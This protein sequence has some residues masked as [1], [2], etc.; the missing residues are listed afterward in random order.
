MTTA[1]ATAKPTP[2]AEG[3]VERIF[4]ASLAALDIFTIYLGDR[5]GLYRVLNE[6]G[7]LD[8]TGLAAAAGIDERYALEWLEQQATT[9]ILEYRGDGLFELPQPYAK[10]L[11]ERDDA[12][13]FAPLARM[14]VSVGGTMPR[15]VEAYKTGAGIDWGDYSPDLVEGQSE[16]NR[17]FFLGSF[18]KDVLPGIPEVDGALRQRGARAAE[19]GFG[20]GWAA[21]AIAGEYADVTVAGF[22]IDG[23]S[24]EMA[25]ANALESGVADRVTFHHVDA[26]KVSGDGTFDVVYAVECIHDMANPVAALKA[27]RDLVKPGGHVLVLDEAVGEE[28]TGAVDDTERFFYGWSATA[29]LLNGRVEQ[30]SNA[31]GT[32]IRP[33]TLERL[34]REAGFSGIEVADVD[35]GF[36]RAYLLK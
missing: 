14:M 21:I 11:A 2:T 29:C 17:P 22:D 3:L 23:P 7:P 15:V 12:N 9:G 26:G 8:A 35:A 28:F 5:L 31:T 36:F 27:M 18:V 32:V 25:N 10:V 30:P 6:R 33:A 24:V 16:L 1:T 4:E 13:Y 19:I 20:G 34:A